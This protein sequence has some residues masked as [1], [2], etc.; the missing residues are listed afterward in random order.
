MGSSAGKQL[1]DDFAKRIRRGDEQGVMEFLQ[2]LSA[3]RA[4]QAP[5]E[6]MLQELRGLDLNAPNLES[7]FT[8]LQLA[9]SVGRAE[10]VRLL[11]DTTHQ[12]PNLPSIEVNARDGRQRTA[13]HFA[14]A[15]K[16]SP[17]W[18]QQRV[19]SAPPCTQCIAD[20]LFR[21]ADP[22]IADVDCRTPLQVARQ[23]R[24]AHCVRTLEDSVKLWQGWVDHDEHA[25]FSLPNWKPS[26]L[27][28]CKDRYPNTGPS[29]AASQVTVSCYNCRTILG[30][31]PYSFR[32][33]CPCC[34]SHVAMTPSLQMAI[35]QPNSSLQTTGELPDT[36]VPT[37]VVPLP[38]SSAY[39]EAKPIEDPGL[40][41]FAG[42]LFEGKLRRALQS[43][44]TSTP[45]GPSRTFGFTM[46]ILGTDGSAQQEHSWRV[47]TDAH[48]HRLLQILAD[49]P[50]ASFEAACD[51]NTNEPRQS[52]PQAPLP[53]QQAIP[54]VIAT[55]VSGNPASSS[56]AAAPGTGW[57]CTRCT[58]NHVGKEGGLSTC[59]MCGAPSPPS[60][61]MVFPTPAALEPSAPAFG[62]LQPSAPPL[63]QGAQPSAIPTGHTHQSS[64]SS[65]QPGPPIATPPPLPSDIAAI[66]S[67][68]PA[69]SVTLPSNAALS[70][71]TT[72]DGMCAVCMERPADTAVV[73]CGHMC[74]CFTC[75]QSLHG[76]P[77]A[78]CPICRG[79][80][81][82]TIRI[83]KN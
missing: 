31:P 47:A 77:G 37:V 54:V 60:Q 56:S 58:Y 51:E 1:L 83:Y 69:S 63:T 35:Y 10:I 65:G 82:S 8:P 16:A 26:W 45:G 62:E 38:M 64:G 17:D 75:M 2:R 66:A 73:P 57:T 44:V 32:V 42:A 14:A 21:N 34:Q 4:G 36:P 29:R 55:A 48:R 28:L 40:K 74:G 72:D 53:A 50:R 39:I 19:S 80:M 49:P 30:A 18:N 20:L 67:A 76:S 7:G 79:P 12:D 13:L 43:T 24:C 52:G 61:P 27:V 71:D 33:V 70:G 3:A 6:K 11:I 5:G 22:C 25:A 68:P 23:F 46:K 9:A 59:A 15:F 78:Q 41:S 81:N